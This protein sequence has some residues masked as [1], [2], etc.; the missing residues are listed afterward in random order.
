MLSVLQPVF[1][2]IS[3]QHHQTIQAENAGLNPI[4]LVTELRT[5][6]M[7]GAVTAGIDVDKADISDMRA[8]NVIQPML[9][10][11]SAV[12][13]AVETV[14]MLLKIDDTLNVR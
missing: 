9:V 3:R 14:A 5:R 6:H 10:T 13:F 2:V 11:K 8:Q 4:Q 1:S 12:R 7:A